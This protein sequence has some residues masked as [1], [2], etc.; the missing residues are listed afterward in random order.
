M[1]EVN[2]LGFERAWAWPLSNTYEN[3][4]G[5]SPPRVCLR[6]ARDDDW[7]TMSAMQAQRYTHVETLVDAS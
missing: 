4:G 6:S 3:D 7:L 2:L 1:S 5:G